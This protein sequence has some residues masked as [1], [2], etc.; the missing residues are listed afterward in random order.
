MVGTSVSLTKLSASIERST[1]T[2][3]HKRSTLFELNIFREDAEVVCIS[4][5]VICKPAIAL[6]SCK[7]CTPTE[8]DIVR[9]L[10]IDTRLASMSEEKDS[11]S[12]THFP[13]SLSYASNSHNCAN[14]F[15]ER[16]DG[17]R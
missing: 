4:D 11:N 3:T 6:Q 14:G 15:M 16:D 2:S 12:L 1:H 13:F 7:I 8:T 9:R 17:T 10:A 5:D